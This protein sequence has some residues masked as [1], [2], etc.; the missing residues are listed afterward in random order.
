MKTKRRAPVLVRGIPLAKII[1]RAALVGIGL[2]FV[3]VFQPWGNALRLGFFVSLVGTITHVVTSHL[4][5]AGARAE[6]G[7]ELDQK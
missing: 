4:D 6:D 2:G 3:L 7:R 5:T 1:D